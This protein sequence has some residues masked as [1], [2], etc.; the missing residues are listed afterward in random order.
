MVYSTET[1]VVLGSGEFGVVYRGIYNSEAVA[2]KVVKSSV[3]VEEFKSVLTEVKI[4]AYVGQHDF[5]VKLI[6]AETSEISRRN[7]PE[8]LLIPNVS[9]RHSKCRNSQTAFSV[10]NQNR[11]DSTGQIMILTE[12][13]P[14]G[15]L[16]Q[17]LR[18]VASTVQLQ[19]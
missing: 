7:L 4:M 19:G 11:L 10:F 12:L 5:I 3:H 15:D 16:L 8:L 13:S 14:E 6:G 18:K 2:I 1:D 9:L 17:Y